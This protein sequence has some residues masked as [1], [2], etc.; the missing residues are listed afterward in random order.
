MQSE[1]QQLIVCG[2]SDSQ[3]LASLQ[4]RIEARISQGDYNR[5]EIHYVSKVNL[6]LVNESLSVDQVTLEKLRQACQ[7]WDIQF[8]PV[9]ISSHRKFIGP[10]IVALKKLALPIIKLLMKDVIE[11][12]RLFNATMIGIVA[13]L[14]NQKSKD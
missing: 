2:Q 10:V 12:Q 6:E 13:R 8:R 3:L 14:S 5:D 1:T 7:L 9:N 11:R 4:A